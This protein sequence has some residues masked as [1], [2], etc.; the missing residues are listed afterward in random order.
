MLEAMHNVVRA[1][2]DLTVEERNLLSVAF[3]N[4]I[5]SRRTAWRV[6]HSIEKKEESKGSKH[7]AILKGYQEKVKGELNRYCSEIIGLIDGQLIQKATNPEAQVFYHKMKGDYY[8]YITEF[9]S[10]A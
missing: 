3:K 2:A 10:G 8:R 7:T 5:S 6:L 4:T 1:N 9:T